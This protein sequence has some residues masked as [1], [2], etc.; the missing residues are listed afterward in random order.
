ME[1]EG[2]TECDVT[3]G[4]ARRGTTTRLVCG[5]SCVTLNSM[6]STRHALVSVVEDRTC[7]YVLSVT[8]PALCKH[9]AF[10][11]NEQSRTVKCAALPDET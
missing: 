6:I 5:D 2:G 3:D 10:I 11:Q 4:V 1:Y 8:T 9:E 7:H